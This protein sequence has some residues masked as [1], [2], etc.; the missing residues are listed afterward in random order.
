MPW[1]P[2]RPCSKRDCPNLVEIGEQFCPEHKREYDREYNA[3]Q[4]DPKKKVAYASNK[5]RLIRKNQLRKHP[6]CQ[7]GNHDMSVPAMEVHHKVKF[8]TVNDPLFSD[9]NNLQS[10]CRNCH[11]SMTAQEG[12]WGK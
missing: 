5:W 7:S 2:K 1:K 8:R 9:P 10:L 12:R 3:K 4:R 6:W 11:S